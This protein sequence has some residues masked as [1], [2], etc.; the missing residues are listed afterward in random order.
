MKFLVLLAILIL[1]VIW[2]ARTKKPSVDA[3]MQNGADHFKQNGI[4]SMVQCRFCGVHL[5]ASEKV[6]NSAGTVFCSEE[7]RLQHAAS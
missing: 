2:L 7:H 3:S 1:V 5:P 6:T 4:E